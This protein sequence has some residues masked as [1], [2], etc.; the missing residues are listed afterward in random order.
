M[1]NVSKLFGLI[2]FI[3]I[4]GFSI[5][6]CKDED[7]PEGD[8][9]PFK[10][11][12][13]R[14]E[15][16][17]D[18]Q[19]IV[20]A[21]KVWRSEEK[22]DNNWVEDI[23]G[24]YTVSGNNIS[25]VFVEVN[26]SYFSWDHSG[27]LQAAQWKGYAE[28]MEQEKE[29]MHIPAATTK[30]TIEGNKFTVFDVTFTKQSGGTGS[31]DNG[32]SQLPNSTFKLTNPRT[33]DVG[34]YVMFFAENNGNYIIGATTVNASGPSAA[35][36]KVTGGSVSLPMWIIQGNTSTRY[37]GNDTVE[38]EIRIFNSA[39]VSENNFDNCIDKKYFTVTFS[40]G[41]ATKKWDDGQNG[42]NGGGN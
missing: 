11:T 26:I 8:N 9:D 24:I 19:K 38:G 14:Q 41:A 2:A 27:P 39:N 29:D 37:H 34:K 40:D 31:G 23:R 16:G 30:T 18:V 10:G 32:N 1:K 21:N 42:P 12:W 35:L 22:V 33:A 15:D 3:A 7:D 6:A 13:Y 5:A 17:A 28:L 25:I 36:V 4:I 20:A